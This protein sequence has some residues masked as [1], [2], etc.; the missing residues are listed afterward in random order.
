MS[1]EKLNAYYEEVLKMQLEMG[2]LAER[3]EQE[4]EGSPE[5]EAWQHLSELAWETQSSISDLLSAV[6]E[7]VDEIDGYDNSYDDDCDCEE[8]Y[9]ARMEEEAKGGN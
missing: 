9:V 8:C 3:M 6:T 2:N 5:F 1:R 4:F 7:Q